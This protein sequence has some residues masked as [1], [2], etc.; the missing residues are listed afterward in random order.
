MWFDS[1]LSSTVSGM[2]PA[3]SPSVVILN[4]AARSTLISFQISRPK[5]RAS[6]P[7]PMFALVAGTLTTTLF[8]GFFW[9]FWDL[10]LF[11]V[12][13]GSTPYIVVLCL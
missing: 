1:P 3:P 9:L 5:P 2:A 7:G 11:I 6:K 12:R 10:T 8:L 4:F 13:G